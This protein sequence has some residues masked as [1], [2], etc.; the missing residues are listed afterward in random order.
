V[1]IAI[2]VF[3]LDFVDLAIGLKRSPADESKLE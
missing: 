1:L 3:F 2:L